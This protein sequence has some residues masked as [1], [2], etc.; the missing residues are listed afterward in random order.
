LLIGHE[1]PKFDSNYVRVDGEAQAWLTD[2]PVGFDRD[3]LSW[4]D[5]RLIDLP[6]ARIA[7]V[8]V[9][10]RGGERFS[11]SHRDD[12]FRLDD[13]PSAAMRDSNQGDAI[14]AALDQLQLEQLA[15]DDGSAVAERE[16]RFSA[17]DGLEV[18]VQAWHVGDALWVRLA[19]AVDEPRAAA[20]LSQTKG[21]PKDM[22]LVRARVADWN[23]RFHGR[24]FQLPVAV[25]T[26]LMLSHEQILAGAPAP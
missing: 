11:L 13:A 15:S 7:R 25:A 23:A 8:Q 9:A 1:H 5:R 6:L 10:D 22:A 14:A 21:A 2:L 12:R 17:V 24:R 18:K 20:W 19:A 26:T 4:L 3:P 16:L